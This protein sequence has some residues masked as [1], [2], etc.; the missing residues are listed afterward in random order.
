MC[1]LY[2]EFVSCELTQ[3]FVLAKMC[4]IKIEKRKKDKKQQALH[5]RLLDGSER[6]KPPLKEE[7]KDCFIARDI[8]S[9]FIKGTI[10]VI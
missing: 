3:T 4:V 7:K 2:V 10:N 1:E 9:L 5:S 8:E 6:R